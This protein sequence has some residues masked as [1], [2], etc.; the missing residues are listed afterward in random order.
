MIDRDREYEVPHAVLVHD[1]HNS[2]NLALLSAL[3]D[4][5][6]PSDLNVPLEKGLS[7]KAS[8]SSGHV[9]I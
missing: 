6:K 8:F 7:L 2:A 1:I 5:A 4:H 9:G 3:A